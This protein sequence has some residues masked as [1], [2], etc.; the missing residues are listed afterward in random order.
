MD[1]I[2]AVYPAPSFAE[3][4]RR[5][6]VAQGVATERVDVVTRMDH[7]RMAHLPDQTF[8]EDLGVQLN[9][10]LDEVWLC[11][12]VEEIADAIQIGKAALVVHPWGQA[13][14]EVIRPIIEAHSPEIVFGQVATEE[15]P[16]RQLG[17]LAAGS[18]R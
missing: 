18:R 9:V 8:A 2:V 12:R 16:N 10:R 5:R 3:R 11:T 13:E 6:L 4:V 1:K 7:G 14:I 17:N 15:V